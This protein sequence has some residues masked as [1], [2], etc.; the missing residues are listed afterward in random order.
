[1]A[2]RDTGISEFARD[3][4]PRFGPAM[5]ALLVGIVVNLFGAGFGGSAAATIV[6]YLLVIFVGYP[7]LPRRFLAAFHQIDAHDS[8]TF[9]LGFHASILALILIVGAFE[10][11][12]EYKIRQQWQNLSADM[13]RNERERSERQ[14]QLW[15][16]QAHA[17]TPEEQRNARVESDKFS[18]NGGFHERFGPRV[19]LA[20]E[21]LN[22]QGF[23]L[24]KE[25]REFCDTRMPAGMLGRLFAEWISAA[26]SKLPNYYPLLNLRLW[27]FLFGFVFLAYVVLFIIRHN[28]TPQSG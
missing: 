17:S 12:R 1:M 6:V 13:L 9:N 28:I 11:A 3:Q 18:F 22:D 2:F 25:M 4:A 16:L 5:C 10:T 15:V 19:A 24:P 26:T 8:V 21:Q 14:H 20:C 27:V 7:D 23:T